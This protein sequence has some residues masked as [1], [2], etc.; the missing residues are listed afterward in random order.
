MSEPVNIKELNE[1]V[2]SKHN[3]VSM[4]IHGMDQTIVGQEHLVDSLLI[5]L[6]AN[7]HVLLEGVPGLAKTLAIKTMAQIIDAKYSRIQFTPDLLPADVVGTMVYSVQKEQ[8]QI[9]RGPIFAN[10]VL[11]D[12]I[13]RAPA[14][15]Q[16]ALLEAMQE[17]QVTIGENT[18]QLDKPFLVMATQNPIEQEGTYPLPEAQV[19]RF[20]L[21]VVIGY[22]TRNEEMKIIRQN[23]EPVKK[24]IVPL[25]RPEEV[26]EAQKIV[27][28]IY[29]DEKIERYIVDIVFATRYPAEYS[30]NDLT[31]IIAF[32][33]SPRASIGLARA[34]RAY[35]FLR[36]RG[37]VIPEDVRAVC[38]DVL[39]H[40][41]GLTYEAEA[42]N[43]S[44]DEIISEILD[45]V[46]VP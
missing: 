25:L 23:I 41:I 13:N 21:K 27:E 14:K 7:G 2:A 19:D 15:V 46:E 26:L 3:F 5:A 1:L 22:P 16:S 37:Y 38:H 28:K 8:F 4:V 10:F 18:F 30:L 35:A 24:D 39:R 44:A 40:R 31:G 9:K 11:A 42:N 45:K 32:G 17:R 36:Q 12:E 34:A 6:L 33:A 43:I 29:L 20:L